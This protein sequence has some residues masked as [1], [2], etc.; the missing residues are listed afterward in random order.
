MII[1]SADTTVTAVALV[2]IVICLIL[3]A[4]HKTHPHPADVQAK[5]DK[6]LQEY[7]RRVERDKA[8]QEP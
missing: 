8:E 5:K 3:L 1:A 6:A 4:W 7:A 2:V